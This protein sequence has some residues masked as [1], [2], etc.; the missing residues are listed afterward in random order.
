MENGSLKADFIYFTE[1]EKQFMQKVEITQAQQWEQLWFT[2][3]QPKYK[4]IM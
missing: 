4:L 3:V 2:A 1:D